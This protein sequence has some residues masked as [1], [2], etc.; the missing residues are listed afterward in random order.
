MV[1]DGRSAVSDG[2]YTV[3]GGRYTAP[4]GEANGN[5]RSR[6]G[7]VR[8]NVHVSENA[9]IAQE[10]LGESDSTITGIMQDTAL[11]RASSRCAHDKPASVVPVVEGHTEMETRNLA[12]NTELLSI[13]TPSV[14]LRKTVAPMK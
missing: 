5:K 14:E 9:D 1:P 6:N 3:P 12:H 2:N 7:R 10:C 4:E 13:K 11:S 8:Q